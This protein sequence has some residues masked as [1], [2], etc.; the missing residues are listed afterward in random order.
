VRPKKEAREPTMGR[1]SPERQAPRRLLAAIGVVLVGILVLSWL[2]LAG[3]HHGTRAVLHASLA[4]A[5][6]AIGLLPD[7]S[8]KHG[9]V[10]L[11]AAQGAGALLLACAAGLM[12]LPAAL[13][14]VLAPGTV[15]ARPYHSLWTLSLDP[16]ATIGELCDLLLPIGMLIATCAWGAAWWRRSGFERGMRVALVAVASVGALHALSGSAELFG[17]VETSLEPPVRF[18]APFINPNHFG[19]ALVLLLPA[20]LA[21][22]FDTDALPTER[23]AWLLVSA[24]AGGLLAV[25]ASSGAWV[26]ACAVVGLSIWRLGGVSGTRLLLVAAG[27]L[28]LLLPWF[29]WFDPR[30]SVTMGDRVATWALGLR[31]VL[32][33]WLTGVGGGNFGVAIQ[34]GLTTYAGWAHAH[35]D[36]VEWLVEF[37]LLGVFALLFAVMRLRPRASRW[38][39]RSDIATIGIV[40]VGVHALVDF[41]LQIP[42]LAMGCALMLGMRRAAYE[43]RIEVSPAKVRSV[44]LAL[45]ALELGASA[46]EARTAAVVAAAES[47]RSQKSSAMGAEATLRKLAPWKA[48]LS[49]LKAWEAERRGAAQ[50]A[51]AWAHDISKT[52]ADDAYVLRVCARILARAGLPDEAT[53]LYDRSIARFPGDWRTWVARAMD[54]PPEREVEAWK[55]AF[56][57]GAPPRYLPAAFATLPLGLA[58]LEAG[59]GRDP[60]FSA[61]LAAFLESRGD[62][63]AAALAYEQ[64]MLIAA[65]RGEREEPHPGYVRALL[66][67]GRTEEAE[68][69]LAAALAVRP[70]DARLHQQH[71]EL[72]ESRGQFEEAAEEWLRLAGNNPV[73]LLNALR[74]TEQAHGAGEAIKL[75]ER[76]GLVGQQRRAPLVVLELARLQREVGQKGRCAT[77]LR[78][79][80]LLSDPK[81]GQRARQLLA[82]CE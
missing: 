34:P 36:W 22:V 32:Q 61:S 19:S 65:E 31:T 20:A 51:V 56:R 54:A 63:S 7:R 47:V 24:L 68:R 69:F 55:E 78:E 1:R 11:P 82:T 41:P 30:S 15:L 3:V 70:E 50:E 58:W 25:V 62:F 73:F 64:S 71:A 35:D 57:A 14:S 74:A 26:A 12:V 67:L 9:G 59:E 48:E 29:A 21:V 43:P 37:G 49:L 77:A 45:A 10:V 66:A 46:W 40:G 53:A 72:L 75:A 52:H 60:R 28:L 8:L 38:T 44:L 42:A 23:A 76:R 33:F 13:R 79:S 5:L 2:A 4:A 17:V 80:D 81:L 6:L 18:Y 27:G 39:G 16:E